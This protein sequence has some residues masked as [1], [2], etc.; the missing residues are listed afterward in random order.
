[1]QA[2]ASAAEE[3]LVF[4]LK[5]TELSE[6][7]EDKFN[8]RL[9]CLERQPET[10]PHEENAV[11]VLRI[12]MDDRVKIDETCSP[13]AALRSAIASAIPKLKAR[14]RPASIAKLELE[15]ELDDPQPTEAA[16]GSSFYQS[17][18]ATDDLEWEQFVEDDA[19]SRIQ[20]VFRGL[21]VRNPA[22]W[23]RSGGSSATAA[24]AEQGLQRVRDSEILRLR[25]QVE[26]QEWQIA[27]QH[28]ANQE[29][30]IRRLK[31][32][33][34]ARE[35]AFTDLRD[36]HVQLRESRLKAESDVSSMTELLRSVVYYTSHLQLRV[37][38]RPFLTDCLWSQTAAGADEG[39]DAAA[40]VRAT[41]PV[42]ARVHAR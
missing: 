34:E 15:S 2:L 38:Y 30:E 3:P 33:V 40:Q 22:K 39:H 24:A 32:E 4:R 14:D 9:Y 16:S 25:A 8:T 20:A 10:G 19:A 5:G 26:E 42:R 29:E 31:A 7:E 1:M 41:A 21:Q 28:A 13:A 36:A 11:S 35:K 27:L 12:R 37:I 6:E 17:S 23:N 18:I